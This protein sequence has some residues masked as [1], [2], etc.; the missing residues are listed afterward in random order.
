[1]GLG[2]QRFARAASDWRAP[3]CSAR[4]QGPDAT[5]GWRDARDLPPRASPSRAEEDV[6]TNQPGYAQC[7]HRARDIAICHPDAPEVIAE[8]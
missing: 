8:L 6:V 7:V 3:T 5:E 1:M 4:A 2:K